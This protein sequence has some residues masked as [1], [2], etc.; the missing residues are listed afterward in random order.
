[1]QYIAIIQIKHAFLC[2]QGKTPKPAKTHMLGAAVQ[3][4]EL[5]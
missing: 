4:S 5:S 2:I 1:M 3:Q